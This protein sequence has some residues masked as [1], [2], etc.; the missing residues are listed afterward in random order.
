MIG[1]GDHR[2]GK[3]G[4]ETWVKLYF[5]MSY[6]G[7]EQTRR[8]LKNVGVIKE[9]DRRISKGFHNIKGRQARE[10][11]GPQLPISV[12]SHPVLSLPPPLLSLHQTRPL[13]LTR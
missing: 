2:V 10:E 3:A 7:F 5:S 9:D 11:S 13:M 12:A 4:I 8:T 6:R 1:R